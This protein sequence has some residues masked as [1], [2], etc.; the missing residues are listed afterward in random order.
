MSVKQC[1]EMEVKVIVSEGRRMPPKSVRM[2][3]IN[4]DVPQKLM[5]PKRLVVGK[6]P[7]LNQVRC[8]SE[9]E[10]QRAAHSGLDQEPLDPVCTQHCMGP[11]DS[12]SSV[13]RPF[14][15]LIPLE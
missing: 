9:K 12:R 8:C 15:E 7:E 10:P 2:F 5:F 1:I 13:Q 11:A 6:Y 14:L 4:G 3:V